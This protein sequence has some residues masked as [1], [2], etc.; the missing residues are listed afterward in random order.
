MGLPALY[1]SGRDNPPHPE[2]WINYF[3]RMVLLYSDK[4]RELSDASN[5]DEISGSLS[6][7]KPREK[8]LL[9]YLL[10]QYPREFTPIEVS[11]EIGV[12]NKTV[13]NRLA[14][15][16]KN[17]FVEPIMVHERI[18]SYQLSDFAKQNEKKI[19]QQI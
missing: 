1:Y 5:A 6:Y 3:L 16:V 11:R 13:I 15:L 7:L 2:I 17:G 12:T 4:V 10:K 18:R 19:V 8:E 14:A 9:L